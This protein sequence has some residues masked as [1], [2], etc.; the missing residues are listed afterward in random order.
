MNSNDKAHPN[1]DGHLHD[2]GHEHGQH[3]HEHETLQIEDDAGNLLGQQIVA[4]LQAILVRK[5]VLSAG[6]VA[7]EIQKLEAILNKQ[8]TSP[9]R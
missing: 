3:L 2:H 1:S 6:E 4:A 7:L 9:C 5:G 8:R